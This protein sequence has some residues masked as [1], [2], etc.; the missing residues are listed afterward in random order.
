MIRRVVDVGPVDQRGDPGVEAFEGPGDIACVHVLI[1]V[2]G[3]ERVQDLNKVVIQ[4]GVGRAASDGG[5]PGVPVGVYEAWDHNAVGCVDHFGVCADVLLDGDDLV[6]LYEYVAGE[7]TDLGI[8]ADDRPP[9]D[10]RLSCHLPLLLCVGVVCFRFTQKAASRRTASTTLSTVGITS[11]SSASANGSGTHS[12]ATR[13]I[14]ASRDS[15]PSSA[16]IAA[17]VAPQPP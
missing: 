17:T 9:A 16:T 5:L 8:H 13:R 4:R 2:R 14:G 11:S 7:I 6:V 15:N 3:S 12:D 10:Q 1:A